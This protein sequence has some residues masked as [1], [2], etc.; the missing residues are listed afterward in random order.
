MSLYHQAHL[1]YEKKSDCISHAAMIHR[2]LKDKDELSRM[3]DTYL[4]EMQQKLDKVEVT[5]KR[6]QAKKPM[7]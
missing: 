1:K 4:R 3:A 5:N 7:V 6:V 2:L